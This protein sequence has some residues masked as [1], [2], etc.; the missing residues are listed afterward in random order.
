MSSISSPTKGRRLLVV[1]SIRGIVSGLDLREGRFMLMAWISEIRCLKVV[2]LTSSSTSRYRKGAFKGDELPLLESPGELREIPP[3]ED[4][5]PFGAV[6]VV[7]FVVLPAP[8]G[9]DVEDDVLAVILSGF[10]FCVR[11][12]RYRPRTHLRSRHH[13]GQQ[14]FGVTID[15][16]SGIIAGQYTLAVASR[17]LVRSTK[18]DQSRNPIE[19][20]SCSLPRSSGVL[21]VVSPTIETTR[22]VQ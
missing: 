2:P 3:G 7:A 12:G 19:K 14:W 1:G 22:R 9:C 13:P 11:F 8:L 21:F 20:S 16:E 15:T 10:G 5:M 18:H 17:K 6:F 4:T